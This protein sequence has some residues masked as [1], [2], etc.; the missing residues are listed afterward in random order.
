MIKNAIWDFDGTLYDT[1]PV[2]L[3]ALLA[4]FKHFNI[5]VDKSKLYREI[6]RGSIKQVF[7]TI[8][9][10]SNIEPKE[11]DTYYHRVE[12][13]KQI[14]PQ[15]FKE[16]QEVLQTVVV[17]GGGNYLLTHRDDAAK[18]YLKQNDLLQY[19]SGFVTSDQKLKRKPAPDA[20]NYLVK[21]FDLNPDET[22]MIGDRPLDVLAGENAHVKTAYFDVDQFHDQTDATVTVANLSELIPLFK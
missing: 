18:Q 14:D 10:R 21:K 8:G 22:V 7:K 6:K 12:A 16:A 15:P 11:L 5:L 1:Y 19:F 20:I 17:N 3:N 9:E 4:T 13:E 2:M